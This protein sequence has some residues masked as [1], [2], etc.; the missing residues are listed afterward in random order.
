[1]SWLQKTRFTADR[2][3]QAWNKT[4]NLWDIQ[5]RSCPSLCYNEER[6]KE[7]PLESW[8]INQYETCKKENADHFTHTKH[9]LSSC[10]WTWDM[11]HTCG[12]VR[13]MKGW[14]EQSQRVY[15][16]TAGNSH[17]L[18]IIS[19]LVPEA[20]F[21]GTQ[22]GDTGRRAA[23]VPSTCRAADIGDG[24]E[25]AAPWQST[26]LPGRASTRPGIQILQWTPRPFQHISVSASQSLKGNSFLAVGAHSLLMRCSKEVMNTL[27]TTEEI[28]FPLS[29]S[30]SVTNKAGTSNWIRKKYWSSVFF[31]PVQ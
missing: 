19:L 8:N 31:S 1:M 13:P 30:C 23:H 12:T 25:H 5:K 4:S 29:F 26:E 15:N 2:A 7:I 20:R 11:F 18:A 9:C 21:P 6:E 27:E 16:S 14:W 3:W 24:N 22:P 17:A 10:L 28:E